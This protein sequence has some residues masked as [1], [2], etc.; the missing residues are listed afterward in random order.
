VAPNGRDIY[1]DDG[2]KYYWINESGKRVFVS[3]KQ[4]KVRQ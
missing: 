1:I 4:L 3:K 2:N